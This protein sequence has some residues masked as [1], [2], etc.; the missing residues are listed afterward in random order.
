MSEF[1]DFFKLI[2]EGNKDYKENDPVGK[3]L[4]KV[5]LNIKSDLGSLFNQIA[6]AKKN[7]PVNK[8]METVKEHIKSDLGSLFAQLSQIA[9]KAEPLD[10]QFDEVIIDVAEQIEEVL[11]IVDETIIE[12]VPLPKIKPASKQYSKK[13]LEKIHTGKSF[14][15]P[16]PDLVAPQMEDIRKKIK[17]MEQAIGRIAATGPGGGEVNLRWLDDI[18]RSTIDD[19][20]Y[21]NYNA[22]TKKFQFSVLSG[23][24]GGAGP[25][26]P[27]GDIGPQ[28]PQGDTGLTGPAGT[29]A[30]GDT[31]AFS[32][33]A[34]LSDQ[35]L[36]TFSYTLYGGAKYIIYATAGADRQV[37][38]ILL[39]HNGVT[40]NI[41]EYANIV[42]SSPLCI[43]TSDIFNANVRMQIT[44][45]SVN[46]NFKIIRTLLP[47]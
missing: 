35:T 19:G 7:D 26:G 21:L 22:A 18:D 47:S 20:K 39:L 32:S 6:E 3:K 27:Q 41:V 38:E 33:D 4:E 15:Q 25:Q 14:Q 8:K 12:E 1:N 31:I 46:I 13:E 29:S 34:T 37:C 43:F 11:E 36:D 28:G 9:T 42:T 2:A 16:N 44:P 23:G 45:I 30:S 40:V 17:F 10:G 24:G 5:K